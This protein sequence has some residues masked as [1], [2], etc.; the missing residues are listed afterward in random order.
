MTRKGY[1][2]RN[3][4]RVQTKNEM[5]T[6]M[7][8]ANKLLKLD[9]WTAIRDAYLTGILLYEYSDSVAYR[10]EDG[11]EIEFYLPKNEMRTK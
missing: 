4:P 7:K 1:G 3:P 9:F 2:G 8:T 6:N 5:R 10:F 11:S